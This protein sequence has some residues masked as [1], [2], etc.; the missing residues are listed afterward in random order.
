[1]TAHSPSISNLSSQKHGGFDYLSESS[2][3]LRSFNW[4]AKKGAASLWL[5]K[6]AY[7]V[8]KQNDKRG[9]VAYELRQYGKRALREHETRQESFT[10]LYEVG[11]KV[12]RHQR[13]AQANNSN[14]LYEWGSYALYRA[15]VHTNLA[16]MAS[17]AR[18]QCNRQN[19]VCTRI[20]NVAQR[21]L[22]AQINAVDTQAELEEIGQRAL[23]GYLERWMKKHEAHKWLIDK[24]VSA[25]RRQLRHA[26]MKHESHCWLKSLA[27]Q[28]VGREMLK[29]RE[30]QRLRQ[31]QLAAERGLKVIRGIPKMTVGV[32]PMDLVER[33]EREIAVSEGSGVEYKLM[34]K[35]MGGIGGASNSMSGILSLT[36]ESSSDDCEAGDGS[37]FGDAAK[38]YSLGSDSIQTPETTSLASSFDKEGKGIFAEQNVIEEPLKKNRT[39]GN[40]KRGRRNSRYK[41]GSQ[42]GGTNQIMFSSTSTPA[43]GSFVTL[44]DIAKKQKQESLDISSVNSSVNNTIKMNDDSLNMLMSSS[45]ANDYIHNPLLEVDKRPRNIGVAIDEWSSART[46]V[47]VPSDFKVQSQSGKIYSQWQP[48]QT[49]SRFGDDLGGGEK[50]PLNMSYKTSLKK[51]ANALAASV[52]FEIISP[53]KF[54]GGG[55]GGGG[56]GRGG[57]GGVREVR[58]EA[59]VGSSYNNSAIYNTDIFAENSSDDNSSYNVSVDISRPMAV[60]SFSPNKKHNAPDRP[61]TPVDFFPTVEN[62]GIPHRLE[63]RPVSPSDYFDDSKSRPAGVTEVEG[64]GIEELF[65]ERYENANKGQRISP[66]YYFKDIDVGSPKHGVAGDQ[67]MNKTDEMTMVALNSQRLAAVHTQ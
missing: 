17:R 47:H 32:D 55:G 41:S 22:Q 10:A 28:A 66:T 21:A 50:N 7:V 34:L 45:A 43:L 49:S 19:V 57:G 58:S 65:T 38:F 46:T 64:G 2:A 23:R 31:K 20:R 25:W 52:G 59:S 18:D 30:A 14:V 5:Q 36:G 33:T 24:G 48:Q 60:N 26:A 61:V 44:A 54:S 16:T 56:G 13:N 15:S 8:V 3:A 37:S 51:R 39:T 67:G 1:M 6:F 42:G 63:D 4:L 12:L 35:T 62:T 40:I 29:A 9:K 11:Q 53:T 27:T